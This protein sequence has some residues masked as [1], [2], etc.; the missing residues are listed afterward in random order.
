MKITLVNLAPICYI[1]KWK[2]WY[3]GASYCSM[4]TYPETG[5][6]RLV[7]LEKELTVFASS[8]ILTVGIGWY[9]F[10]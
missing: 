3:V 2:G 6:E 5:W 8:A 1:E 4:P 9:G 7:I 10:S